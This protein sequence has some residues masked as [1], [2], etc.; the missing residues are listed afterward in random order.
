M[1]CYV[2]PTKLYYTLGQSTNLSA[3]LPL[4]QF[5]YFE[6]TICLDRHYRVKCCITIGILW[7]NTPLHRSKWNDPNNKYGRDISETE[8]RKGPN[9]RRSG[10]KAESLPANLDSKCG[11]CSSGPGA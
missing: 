4:L 10:F 8:G 6:M 11:R 2:I 1:F 5:I 3:Y 7:Q 9:K